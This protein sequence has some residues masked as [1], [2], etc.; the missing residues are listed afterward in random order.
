WARTRSSDTSC[1]PGSTSAERVCAFAPYGC[2]GASVRLAKL[3]HEL[4][5]RAGRTVDREVARVLGVAQEIAFGDELEAGR[6]DLAA[7]HR[8]FDAMERLSHRGAA[9]GA[10]IEHLH[11]RACAGEGEELHGI[12]ALVDLAVRVAAVGRRHD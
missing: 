1:R 7:Q 4:V 8:L 9:A 2:A 10:H 12:A 3:E 5:H 6:L 11:A